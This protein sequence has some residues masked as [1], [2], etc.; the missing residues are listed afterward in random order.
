M[1]VERD[2][3]YVGSVMC[4]ECPGKDCCGKS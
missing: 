3:S 2:P 1:E 4:P